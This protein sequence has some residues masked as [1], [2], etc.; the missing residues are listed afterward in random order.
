MGERAIYISAVMTFVW[1]ALAYL[2]LHVYNRL[3]HIPSSSVIIAI[4]SGLIAGALCGVAVTRRQL[5]FLTKKSET[6]VTLITWLYTI[7]AL[8]ITIG[9]VLFFV[10]SVPP[11]T[12]IIA[13]YFMAPMVSASEAAR[14]ILFV[15]WERKHKRIILLPSVV[16]NK[17]YVFPKIEET[18]PSQN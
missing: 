8:F 5:R 7:G 6:R 9:V 12:V 17:M 4:T 2:Q 15:N 11:E 18:Q 10:T 1:A 3:Y 13:T 16:S 14:T